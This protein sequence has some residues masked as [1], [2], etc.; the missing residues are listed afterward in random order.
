MVKLLAKLK[1]QLIKKKEEAEQIAP[2][3][4]L[5]KDQEL[6]IEIRDLLKK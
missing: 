3:P 6:L 1:K 4:K 5:S 2:L